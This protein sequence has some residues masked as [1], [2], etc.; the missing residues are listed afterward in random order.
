[1][2]A[3][4]ERSGI[5]KPNQY[6]VR[7]TPPEALQEI[8][9]PV[10]RDLV[11]RTNVAQIP[12]EEIRTYEKPSHSRGSQRIVSGRSENEPIQFSVI[13]SRT[14]LERAFFESWMD[15]AVDRNTNIPR[16]YDEY[17]G[18][19]KIDLLSTEDSP[20]QAIEDDRVVARYYLYDVFPSGLGE[21]E[22]GYANT[23]EFTTF[24]VTMTYDRWMRED[25]RTKLR[26]NTPSYPSY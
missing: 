19:I 12:Q 18:K 11:I 26:T 4:L 7:F 6:R 25:L 9:E 5:H 15:Y 1:M 22:L 24:T 16:F 17:I 23:D 8:W 10:I 13:A 14:L 3:S 21:I 20:P 2:I